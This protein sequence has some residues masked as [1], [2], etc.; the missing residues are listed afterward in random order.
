MK[1][2]LSIFSRHP[3]SVGET[4]RQ[5]AASA[6]GFAWG[7]QLAALAALVHAFFPFLFVKTASERIACLYDRMVTHRL[8]ST[9]SAQSRN[10]GLTDT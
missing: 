2:E 5:H 4:W 9:G 8:R 6:C 10:L 7:L 1:T 3:A